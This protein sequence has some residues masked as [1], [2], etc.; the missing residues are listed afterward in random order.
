M[1]SS[2]DKIL[3]N[4][5]VL[6]ESAQDAMSSASD[7]ASVGLLELIND[8][9]A[10]LKTRKDGTIISS[11][12]N[13]KQLQSIKPQI[14]KYLNY[15]SYSKSVA[16]YLKEFKETRLLI[17]SYFVSIIED[18]ESNTE[19]YKAIADNNVFTTVDAL[20]NT[21][22]DANFKQPIIEGLQKQVGTGT[23]IKE[24]KAYLKGRL[25]DK[26]ELNRYVDQVASDSIRQF[27]RQ[28]MQAVSDDLGLSHYL[29]RGTAI[30]DTREFCNVRHG[31]YY[32]KE[33][34]KSWAYLTPW[35]GQIRGT[36]ETNIFV[37]LGGYKCRHKLIPV[38]RAIYENS[39]K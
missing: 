36:N 11:I 21:G 4:I 26:P 5:E 25:I 17:D 9:L 16:G 37:Y 29:Y 32:T 30:S 10:S 24:L 8:S 31:K 33:Q 27:E 6:M 38:S 14:D 13:L 15:G 23:S 2:Q 20:L 22:V 18:Y 7:K 1:T 12:E 34:V 39:K 3:D 28:Y 19:I 35:S